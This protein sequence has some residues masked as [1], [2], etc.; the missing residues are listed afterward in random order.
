MYEFVS[1]NNYIDNHIQKG[2]WPK[3]DGV[4]EHT[5]LLSQIILDA[6]RKS[7]GLI[8]TLLDLKNAFGEV[9]HDLIR[10]SLNY[11]HLPSICTDIFNSIYH[12]SSIFVAVKNEWT[13]QLMVERGVLQGDP[14]SP[15]MFNLCFNT[16]MK[17]LSKPEFKSLG[18]IWGP[19]SKTTT[20]SWLQFA[21]DAVI[22]ASNVKNT[23]QLL[24]I[25]VAWCNW[26]DML[27]RLDKC[28]SFGMMKRNNSFDQIEPGVYVGG[29]RIPPV[30][31]G[32]SFT[33]LGKL[34]EFDMKNKLAKSEIC[35]KLEQLLKITSNLK[36]AAQTKLKILKRYIHSQLQF[37]LKIYPLG[38]TWI[39][40]NMDASCT[41]HVRSWLDMPISSCIN[42]VMALPAEKCGLNIPSFKDTSEKL[43]LQKRHSLKT[44]AHPL[45]NQLWSETSAKNIPSDELLMVSS[46]LNQAVKNLKKKQN[47]S[48]ENM[49]FSLECQGILSKTVVESVKKANIITWSNTLTIMPEPVYNFARKAMQQQLPTAANLA[50]WKKTSD[51]SCQLCNSGKPQTNKHVLSNCS[52]LAALERY[53]RRHNGILETLADWLASALSSSQSLFVD[54]TSEKFHP[55]GAVF[56]ATAR[57]DT[58]IR[59]DSELFVL[60][61][62]VCHESNLMPSKAYK[63]NKYKNLSHH[64][65]NEYKHY[66]IRLFTLEVSTLG[67]VSD[68]D[69]FTTALGL[70]KLPNNIIQTIIRQALFNSFTIYCDRNN[71][72]VANNLVIR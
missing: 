17:T 58:V 40:Q 12:G 6:K 70:S 67:F 8:V 45:M 19:P 51:S 15:L 10:A 47:K 54:I 26:A 27:I 66:T 11:H 37:E 24:N 38:T 32:G 65:N 55:V 63:L 57:P 62:T 49:F 18:Y 50:R 5:E 68:T 7:R 42:E 64:L 34:F 25:F 21:D 16:L 20:C 3:V 46:N 56:R 43:W 4:T 9:H 35:N 72:T 36:V 30:P 33:Y 44:S 1:A 41:R 22:I 53:K 28:S 13:S 60:E 14:C 29:S 2:F 59:H 71:G 23:Q 52:S 31:I 69:E 48:S 61:L 39:E